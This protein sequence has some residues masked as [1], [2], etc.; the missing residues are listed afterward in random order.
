[1]RLLLKVCIENHRK[2]WSDSS[3]LDTNDDGV[4]SSEGNYLPCVL[5]C[6]ELW[7]CTEDGGSGSYSET[8]L[9]RKR[10]S[11]GVLALEGNYLPGVL[12]CMELWVCTEDGGSGSYSE[13][14]LPRKRRSYGVLALEGN[15]LPGVLS[16]M[17]LWVCTEDGGSGSYS[18]T[19]LPRKKRSSEQAGEVK[20]SAVQPSEASNIPNTQVVDTSLPIGIVSCGIYMLCFYLCVGLHEFSTPEIKSSTA[21]LV[22]KGGFGSVYKGTYQH[23]AV[24]VK[25]LNAVE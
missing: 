11:Y 1:M 13:T 21:E 14:V 24:A 10:R 16:C 15:Y 20:K 2:L 25:V 22:G 4:L 6:M 18:A 12:S 8:V 19:V 7:V 3:A 5:S 17:E 9:P 23:L